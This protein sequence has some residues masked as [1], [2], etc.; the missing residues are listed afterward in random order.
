MRW[1]F[2]ALTVLLAAG[3]VKSVMDG[4]IERVAVT[5][6]MAMLAMVIAL[7]LEILERTR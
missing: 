4:F 3:A 1:M 6:V 2:G 7:L 5:L